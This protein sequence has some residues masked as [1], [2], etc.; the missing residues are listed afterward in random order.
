MVPH[1]TRPSSPGRCYC[2]FTLQPTRVLI[3]PTRCL[4]NDAAILCVAKLLVLQVST[5]HHASSLPTSDKKSQPH[6]KLTPQKLIPP[7]PPICETFEV[8]RH[9]E[10]A[11]LSETGKFTGINYR[12]GWS[13]RP[14]S[15]RRHAESLWPLALGRYHASVSRQKRSRSM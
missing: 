12:R 11:A 14:L 7:L 13:H 3:P 8:W 15:A 2:R 10:I 9:D 6:G 5:D 4:M 1:Q